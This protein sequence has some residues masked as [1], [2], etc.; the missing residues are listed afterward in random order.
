MR[1]DPTE[2]NDLPGTRANIRLDCTPSPLQSCLKRVRRERMTRREHSS[3]GVPTACVM[4]IMTTIITGSSAALAE[5]LHIYPGDSFEE[6]VENL[7]PGDTLNVH[8]GTYSESNRIS[9]RAIGTKL[10]PVVIRAADGEKRPHITRPA[11]AAAQNTINI[12]GAEHLTIAGLEIS[13]NGGDGVRLTDRPAHITLDDLVIHDVS[14]GI[15]FRSSMHDIVVRR[16]RIF[17]TN[18]TG[19]GI[20]VGCDHGQCIVRNALIEYNWIYDTLAATQGDG[21]EIKPGSHSNIIRNNVI[22]DTHWPCILLYGTQGK[23]RNIVEGNLMWNCGDSGIQ[24]AAD[25]VIRNNIV[26]DSPD[27]GFNSRPHQGISPQ[28]LEFV[29]NTIIGG[30]PCLYL[31]DWNRKTGLIF[32]NNVVYCGN[33]PSRVGRLG[34]VAAS[35]NV[36]LPGIHEFP[37][38]T[39]TV[40][41]SLENDFTD[42]DNRNAYP[43]PESALLN[44]GDADYVTELDFNGSRRQGRVDAGAFSRSRE[45]GPGLDT[46]IGFRDPGARAAVEATGRMSPPPTTENGNAASPLWALLVIVAMYRQADRRQRAPHFNVNYS[47]VLRNRAGSKPWRTTNL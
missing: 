41:N 4:A 30:D 43:G 5:T 28:N 45:H 20:Y 14:V 19:E 23:P 37:T 36:F 27:I 34:G 13:S 35:G 18:N 31:H 3:P 25:A 2:L 15:N 32:A 42:L 10:A 12:E 39:Y 46:P 22:H 11:N 1:S 33:N 7:R 38:N 21:I 40:G 44:A 47:A 26:L 29:H 6:A 24:A 16:S 9:I 8:A 17:R